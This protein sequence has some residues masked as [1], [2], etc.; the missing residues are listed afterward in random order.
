MFAN[1]EA[2]QFITIPLIRG[3]CIVCAN[4]EAKQFITIPYFSDH[5]VHRI[6]RQSQ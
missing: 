6:I 1:R 5:K 3:K 2:N 4:L